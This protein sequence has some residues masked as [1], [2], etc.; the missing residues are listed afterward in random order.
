M[1]LGHEHLKSKVPRSIEYIK[2]DTP[3][4]T[5]KLFMDDSCLTTARAEDMQTLLNV[6]Q[7]YVD[8][9]RFKLK[10]SK[11][12]ALV[13]KKGVAVRWV[14]E[15]VVGEEEVERELCLQ[16]G[17]EVIP[18][19]SEKPIKFLGRWIRVEGNDKSV[20]DSTKVDLNTFLRRLDESSLT[21]LQKCWGY[22]YM[23]LPKL[24]W[25]LAIYDIPFTTVTRW[26]Q[27]TNSFLRKWLG[28]GHT[29]SGLC[30]F[31]QSSSVALPVSSLTDTWKI[32][33]CRLLQSYQT[34]KDDLIKAVQPQVRSG[35]VW[36]PETE[37]EEA[38][39]D[40]VCESVRGMVQPQKRVGIG[41]GDWKKPWERMDERERERE[42]ML[43]VKENIEREREVQV[44]SL[45]M[46][47]RWGEWR[48]LV[49]K[50]DLSWHTLFKYGDSLIGFM[51]SAV[52]GTLLTPSMVSKWSEDEDGKCKLCEERMGTIQHILAGCKVALSQGRYRWRHDKVLKQISEQ[53][54]F[55]CDRRVNTYK[56]KAGNGRQFIDFV[57]A[58]RRKA[59]TDDRKESRGF[60][61][62][63]GYRDWIVLSDLEGQ[64]K[65]P[66]E[67]VETRLRPDLVI[68]S[69]SAKTVIWWEL[70]V[71]SEERIAE[72]H[73]YKLDR[74]SGL[75]AEIQAKGWCCY[76]AAVEV[77]ARG[78]VAQSL[79][80]AARRIGFRGRELKKLVRDSGKEAAHC[81]RWIYLLSRKREWEFRKVGA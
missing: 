6:F 16:L 13:L 12:R 47:S 24:K 63:S 27:N 54:V 7:K 34:S 5:L 18:N 8:W 71:P 67:I 39:R 58:G 4:P 31:S 73:E 38:R 50:T 29:L 17:G 1:N 70:T 37:L 14:E 64:L 74:Y 80:R 43:R 68:F 28:V 25:P 2:D 77:G 79:E 32:E 46:Q 20:I 72:S 10:S 30:L 81:S 76:N 53:V 22:Q 69:R 45:E 40:L 55:H 33:K 21:G 44:G 9:S 35:R 59:G 41:F 78:V 51:L 49:M 42:V 26:E 75:Q 15:V 36:R 48:E 3:I 62:L 65:F 52:Y 57:P 23:V 11:S 56:N 19:V 61:I 66:S 60:G